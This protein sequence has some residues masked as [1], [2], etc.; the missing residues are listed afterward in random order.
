MLVDAS[1]APCPRYLIPNGKA[2]DPANP[3]TN[4]TGSALLMLDSAYTCVVAALL[5]LAE[6]GGPGP[7][8]VTTFRSVVSYADN[9]AAL[10]AC[11]NL[12]WTDGLPN[13]NGIATRTGP[14]T[15]FAE[16]GEM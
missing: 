13:L 2:A 9:D 8:K 5:T 12:G 7:A 14:S 10:R 16:S 6:N 15:L 4:D 1:A 3:E 11:H